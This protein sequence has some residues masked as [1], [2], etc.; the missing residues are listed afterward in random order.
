MAQTR[1]IWG[2]LV[3]LD[4]SHGNSAGN[5]EQDPGRKQAINQTGGLCM[6]KD[7]QPNAST[8]NER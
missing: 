8:V 4:S 2:P 7:A 3:R 5:N 6:A 1:T